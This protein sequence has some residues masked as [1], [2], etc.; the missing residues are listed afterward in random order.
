MMQR[1]N[2]LLLLSSG[3]KN[4]ENLRK[5]HGTCHCHTSAAVHHPYRKSDDMGLRD[6]LRLPKFDRRKRSKARSEIGN[7]NEDGPP[8]QRPT[9]STPDLRI[10]TSTSPPI[11]RSSGSNNMRAV[12]SQAIHLETN[13]PSGAGPSVSRPTE[14]TPDLRIGTS[15][16]LSV[17]H[18][19][20]N[21]VWTVSSQS[22][23]LA[24]LLFA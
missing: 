17:P 16:E 4:C 20:P 6:F 10:G 5:R 19:E 23:H 24:I 15:T 2:L 14:S 8:V 7:A 13:N 11:P 12:S 9:E 3:N 18:P 21:G 1:H 22:N